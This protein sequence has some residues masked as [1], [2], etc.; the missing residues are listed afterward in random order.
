MSAHTPIEK[1]LQT[2]VH[3]EA[4]E[5]VG[6]RQRTSDPILID[7]PQNVQIRISSEIICQGSDRLQNQVTGLTVLKVL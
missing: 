6:C 1:T 5:P 2:C 7:N 3:F 4:T